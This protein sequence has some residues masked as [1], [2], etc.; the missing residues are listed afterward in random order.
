MEL[1][2]AQD[3]RSHQRQ[4][5]NTLDSLQDECLVEIL[6]F[7]AGKVC[8]CQPACV[9]ARVRRLC[10]GVARAPCRRALSPAPHPPAAPGASACPRPRVCRQGGARLS[11]RGPRSG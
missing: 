7:V 3:A 6:R 1:E 9:L 8:E 10:V 2:A 5:A 11:Q 4:Q